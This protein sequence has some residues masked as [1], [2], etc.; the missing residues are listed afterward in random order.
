MGPVEAAVRRHVVAGQTLLTPTGA[1]FE[2]AKMDS[3]GL[4]LLMGRKKA[5]TRVP[6][7]ALEGIPDLLR[8]RGWVP[9]SG[10]YEANPDERTFDGY[11]KTHVKRATGNWVAVVLEEAGVLELDRGRPIRA[12]LRRSDGRW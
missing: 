10:A 7:S 12:Q 11:L 1:P 9:T 6:W 2:V 5:H 4:V 3:R 8:G